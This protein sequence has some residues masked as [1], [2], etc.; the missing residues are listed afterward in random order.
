MHVCTPVKRKNLPSERTS[1]PMAR[2]VV[3]QKTREERYAERYRARDAHEAFFRPK[4]RARKPHTPK[5]KPKKRSLSTKERANMARA[6]WERHHDDHQD[7]HNS[8]LELDFSPVIHGHH[9]QHAPDTEQRDP[10][11]SSRSGNEEKWATAAPQP[12]YMDTDSSC[13]HTPTA[14]VRPTQ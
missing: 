8:H 4:A 7:L 1:S 10:T 12:S 13:F 11:A 6:H 3:R 14:R 5:R 9:R 2:K